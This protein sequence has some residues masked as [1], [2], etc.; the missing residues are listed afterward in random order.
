M[1]HDITVGHQAVNESGVSDVPNN[2][3]K[4]VRRQPL[5]GGSISR[6]SQLIEDG[7]GVI[8]VIQDIVHKIG[9]DETGATG[10]EEFLHDFHISIA[11][12]IC[13]NPQ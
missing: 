2:E 1:N 6:V 11:P 8:C 9:T 13:L 12:R 7:D 3:L 5:K 10:H 4:A